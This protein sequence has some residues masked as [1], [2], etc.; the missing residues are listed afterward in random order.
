M[1]RWWSRRCASRRGV[2]NKILEA[3]SMARPVIA[4][5]QAVEG[6]EAQSGRDLMIAEAPAAFVSAIEGLL[7]R[8]ADNTL[9]TAARAFV[10][11][12]Y[13]WADNLRR[14]SMLC[15]ETAAPSPAEGK[16]AV[17]ATAEQNL[18]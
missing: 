10:E 13:G 7:A 17:L 8:R 15:G 18:S 3:M 4:T 9:G 12:H 1:P 16:A 5:P 14:L 2:Q 11:R 6:I